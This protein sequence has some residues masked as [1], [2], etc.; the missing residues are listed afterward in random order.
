MADKSTHNRLWRGRQ[1]SDFLMIL[2]VDDFAKN[3]QNTIKAPLPFPSLRRVGVF[4]YNAE[5]SLG[6]LLTAGTL[7][8]LFHPTTKLFQTANI[9]AAGDDGIYGNFTMMPFFALWDVFIKTCLSAE[10]FG[11]G[12]RICLSAIVTSGRDEGGPVTAK[13]ADRRR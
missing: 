3:H 8:L 1:V 12:G 6:G 7:A 10:A 4:P 2:Q 5:D 11:G 13:P 9:R